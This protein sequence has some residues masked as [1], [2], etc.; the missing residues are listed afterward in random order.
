MWQNSHKYYPNRLVFKIWYH[1][2][3]L[4]MNH[5]WWPCLGKYGHEGSK[6]I[7]VIWVI[8][9]C[10]WKDKIVYKNKRVREIWA[11]EAGERIY[12]KWSPPLLFSGSLF[13]NGKYEG[14]T[15]VVSP[16][17]CLWSQQCMDGVITAVSFANA[18]IAGSLLAWTPFISQRCIPLSLSL[19]PS[20]SL[21][22]CCGDFKI[23]ISLSPQFFFVVGFFGFW[24]LKNFVYIFH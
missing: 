13:A 11:L 16:C 19:P 4:Q 5:H 20:L 23:K 24:K 21:S 14:D 17:T 10:V 6:V 22:L 9:F 8:I 3:V 2:Y 18:F 12:V 15:G 1:V 7:G